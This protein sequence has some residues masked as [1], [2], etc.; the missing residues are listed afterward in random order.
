MFFCLQ[1][2]VLNSISSNS[3]QLQK[4]LSSVPNCTS[5][6]HVR[7]PGPVLLELLVCGLM[8]L[9]MFLWMKYIHP[10]SMVAKLKNAQEMQSQS[11]PLQAHLN[12]IRET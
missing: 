6:E 5:I 1:Q 2:I 8:H 7:H 10:N 12:M 3:L 11:S 9:S 4:P